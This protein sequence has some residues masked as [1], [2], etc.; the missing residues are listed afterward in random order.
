VKLTTHLHLEPRLRMR[1]ITPPLPHIYS[2]SGT[3]L[4][5]GTTLTLLYLIQLYNVGNIEVNF[6]L[7]SRGIHFK[8]RFSYRLYWLVFHVF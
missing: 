3:W 7:F 2:W 5:A 1:G 6:H 8:F 4:G